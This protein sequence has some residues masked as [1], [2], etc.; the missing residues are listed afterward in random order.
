MT[1]DVELK[2]SDGSVKRFRICDCPAPDTAGNI[3]LPVDGQLISAR[4]V[5]SFGGRELYRSANGDRWYLVS[6]PDQARPLVRHEP[7]PASG[8]KV[9]EV[10]IG[11]FLS[12]GGGQ[13]PEHLEL[14]RLIGTLVQNE[15]PSGI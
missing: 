12:G 4:E 15:E 7:N 2:G 8:G 3:D 1:Y 13:G 9:T 10:E 6:G 5:G 14:L 11:A